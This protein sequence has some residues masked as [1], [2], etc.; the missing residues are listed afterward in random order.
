MKTTLAVLLSMVGVLIALYVGRTLLRSNANS[1]DDFAFASNDVPVG[2]EKT[3]EPSGFE[4]QLQAIAKMYLNYGRVDDETRWAPYLC[5]QP[6]PSQVRYSESD[7]ESTHGRKLYFLYAR[8]RSAY[9]NFHNED[10]PVGQVLVKESWIPKQLQ[11]E[12]EIELFKDPVIRF[13]SAKDKESA[14]EE[15]SI[16][17]D[18]AA[19][20]FALGSGSANPVAHRNGKRWLASERRELFIMY[21]AKPDTEGT[22]DGWVYGTVSHDG[23]NVTSSGRVTSCID[24]QRDANRDRM[25]GLAPVR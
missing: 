6:M 23:K 19:V 12:E 4:P 8:H 3:N 11:R 2:S 18:S 21:K 20:E 22:D 24:C 1:M 13:E 9:L 15:N 10:Q 14:Y 7:D 17:S 25:F 16:E 5:R